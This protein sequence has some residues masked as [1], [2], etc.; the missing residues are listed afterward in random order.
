M[1][2]SFLDYYSNSI[3]WWL[4]YNIPVFYSAIHLLVYALS[5]SP[6]TCIVLW[7]TLIQRAA[8]GRSFLHPVSIE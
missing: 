2:F 1:N 8:S 7:V 3:F 4:L 6:L 5:F